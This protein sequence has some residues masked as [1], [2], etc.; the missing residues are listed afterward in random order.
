M[1][2]G[3]SVSNVQLKFIENFRDMV[4][5]QCVACFI[6]ARFCEKPQIGIPAKIFI[7]EPNA[8]AERE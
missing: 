4:V 6:G 2:Y 8:S 3:V 5:Q 1:D 7:F